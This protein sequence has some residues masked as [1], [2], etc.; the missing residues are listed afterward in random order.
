MR[1]FLIH[2]KNGNQIITEEE[3]IKN[4]RDQEKSGLAPAYSFY[5]FRKKETITP[6]G[7]LIWST[8]EDGCGVV[9]RG[10]GGAFH[11]V[12]GCQGDFIFI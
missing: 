8:Y 9:Y 7:W 2:T 6:P 11:L 12:T 1:K 4:A 10:T 5:D 3:A